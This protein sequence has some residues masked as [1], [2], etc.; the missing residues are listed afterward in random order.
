MTISTATV[1]VVIPTRY[2]SDLVHRAVDSALKQTF[3]NIEVVVVIDGPD[4]ATSN[5][6]GTIHDSR[7]RV[8][9]LEESVGG[10]EARNRG[11]RAARG[12]W[13]AFLDDDDEWL[14]EKIEKQVNRAGETKEHNL[15]L[16]CKFIERTENGDRVLPLRTPDEDENISEYLYCPKGFSLGEGFV[17]TSTLFTQRALLLSIPFVSGLKCG[18]ET[19]WLLKV[20]QDA[21]AR[22]V[23]ISDVLAIFHDDQ[24]RQRTSAAPAWRPLYKWA[25]NNP[26]YFTRKAYSFFVA[27]SC[28][29]YAAKA[30]EPP[31]VFIELFKSCLTNGAPTPKCIV[32]F[33]CRALLP[34]NF[35]RAA[36]KALSGRRVSS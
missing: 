7:L 32:L 11:V 10:A 34:L 12:K 9:A 26:K 31:A 30:K 19:T 13:I 5:S 2:R 6:L 33:L 28:A 4:P 35:R 14:P 36:G 21:N 3:R 22:I 27:T 18:Q 8:I 17:Q 25:E 15:V 29:T 23:I 20:A 24:R 16:G 1:S